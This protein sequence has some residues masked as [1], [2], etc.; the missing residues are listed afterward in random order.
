MISDNHT[1]HPII[2]Y[3]YNKQPSGK[4]IDKN[5]APSNSVA[6]T[7]SGSILVHGEWADTVV[8]VV[9]VVVVAVVVFLGVGVVFLENAVSLITVLFLFPHLLKCR[10]LK[11]LSVSLYKYA[12]KNDY[13]YNIYM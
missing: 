12:F 10:L 6:S 1:Y 11:E 2:S 9:V 3:L 4:P 8:V 5:L 7:A 13:I